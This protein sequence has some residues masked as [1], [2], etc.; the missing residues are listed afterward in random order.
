MS[1]PADAPDVGVGEGPAIVPYLQ[2]ILEELKSQLPRADVLGILDQL[3]N[4]MRPVAVQLPEE[5]EHGCVRAVPGDVLRTDLVVVSGHRRPPRA[6]YGTLKPGS[7]EAREPG[8]PGAREAGSPGA[9]KRRS[10][11]ARTAG[12]AGGERPEA[13]SR[14]AGARLAARRA[15]AAQ[16]QP[17]EPEVERDSPK[18][19]AFHARK[20][21]TA[22]AAASSVM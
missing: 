7:P 12:R 15:A 6:A 17:E 14:G 21:V 16:A 11:G 20:W 19:C 4:E 2:P 3:E 1:D 9:R 10:A 8:S 22:R 5:I 18:S 13:G